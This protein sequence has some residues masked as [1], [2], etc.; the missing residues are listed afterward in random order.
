MIIKNATVFCEDGVFREGEVYVSGQ[1]FASEAGG[2]AIDA[3]GAYLIPGLIDI[4]L[5]GCHGFDFSDG[6]MDSVIGMIEY[7][8]RH[9][10][11]TILPTSMAIA[12]EDILR[13]ARSIGQVFDSDYTYKSVLAGMNME[14][15]FLSVDRC[16]AQDPKH[17]MEP[18]LEFLFKV[19]RQTGNR[20]KLCTIAPELEGAS[21]FIK[22]ASKE[23][24]VSIGHTDADYQTAKNAFGY[25]ASHVTHLYNAMPGLGHRNPSVI[26]A[27]SEEKNVYAELIC[28]GEHVHPAAIRAAFALFSRERIV[29]IS[30]SMRATGCQ[31]GIYDLGGQDVLVSGSRASLRNGS[32]AGSVTNLMDAVRFLYHN[33]CIS[34]NDS[35][36]CASASAA[37]SI[38]MY[39]MIGSISAGKYADFVM[40]DKE[41]LAIKSIYKRGDIVSG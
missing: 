27:A 6:G 18:D 2:Q 40:L 25:G 9:G 10:I 39:D 38:G 15:P 31:D 37:K 7:E 11:T 8:L 21:E 24:V 4:H 36:Y 28:D 26:G 33:K 14:G 5:H 3:K 16:G 20:L 22:G 19:H 13:A 17:L 32:L 12:K 23:L 30:D 1:Y 29:L 34:L 35:I 41:T